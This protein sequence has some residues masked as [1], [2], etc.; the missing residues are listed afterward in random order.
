MATA[1]PI[2][3]TSVA[4]SEW[5]LADVVEHLGGVPLER[6]RA[7]P[8]LGTATEKDVLESKSRYN[9][10]CELIDGVLVEKTMGFYESML[11]SVLI[12]CLDAHMR[13]HDAGIVLD[14]SGPLRILPTQV[15][16]PDVSVILWERFPGGELPKEPIPALAPDLAVEVLSPSNTEKEM[17]QK[18][19]DYFLSGVRLVWY[20]DPETRTAEIFLA[21]EQR[22]VITEQGILDGGEVL[23]GFQVALG[24]LFARA[25]RRGGSGQSEAVSGIPVTRKN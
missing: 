11:A 5:A 4:R 8:P 10:I 21:P 1:I 9:R 20:I 25:D 24:E 22:T 16:I 23:P 12:G 14:G 17:R 6:I 18:L 13:Q 3:P 7:F 15:R 19:R 2:S